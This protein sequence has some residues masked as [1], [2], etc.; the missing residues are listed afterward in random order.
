MWSQYFVF[1]FVRNPWVRA[2]S[3][4]N[5]MMRHLDWQPVRGKKAGAGTAPGTAANEGA[6]DQGSEQQQQQRYQYS[7]PAARR[8]SWDN[9]CVDPSSFDRVCRMDSECSRWALRINVVR[10]QAHME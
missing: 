9:F 5:M 6:L 1:T 3:A 7:L 10:N 2:V 4:Y 8:Y